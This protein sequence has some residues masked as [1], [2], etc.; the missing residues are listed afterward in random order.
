[1]PR[2]LYL[3]GGREDERVSAF[4]AVGKE[5]EA[6]GG[7]QKGGSECKEAFLPPALCEL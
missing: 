1:M 7:T 5:K 2:V 6:G 3:R 4:M